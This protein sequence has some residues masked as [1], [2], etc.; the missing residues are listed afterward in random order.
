M[1]R[2]RVGLQAL[3]VAVVVALPVAARAQ[4][5]CPPVALGTA[6]V[7]SPQASPADSVY[8]LLAA[9]QAG[10]FVYDLGSWYFSLSTRGLSDEIRAR[11]T[12]RIVGVPDGTPVAFTLEASARY[13]YGPVP[14]WFIMTWSLDFRDDSPHN[15]E[16][17]QLLWDEITGEPGMAANQGVVVD[18]LDMV[19]PAGEPL[20]VKWWFG[21]GSAAGHDIAVRV[22][23]RCVGLPPGAR[24]VSCHG[25]DSQ[26][27]PIHPATWGAVKLLYR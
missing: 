21:G 14:R 7:S 27:T 18:H 8:C 4:Q 17:G 20:P 15:Y 5:N 10:S 19:R 16:P 2:R 11:D 6:C 22:L 12:L 13:S 1:S 3:L 9:D 23:F 26:P 25:F 24:L